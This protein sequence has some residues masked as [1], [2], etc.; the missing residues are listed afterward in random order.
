MDGQKAKKHWDDLSGD[1]NAKE[2]AGKLEVAEK[3]VRKEYLTG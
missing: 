3:R 2:L 1:F